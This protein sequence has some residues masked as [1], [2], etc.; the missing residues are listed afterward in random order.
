MFIQEGDSVRQHECF[1]FKIIQST[2]YRQ[3]SSDRIYLK[4]QSEFVIQLE[5][6]L[7]CRG[8]SYKHNNPGIQATHHPTKVQE[9]T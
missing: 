5:Q 4:P 9:C 7:S 8:T 1:S 6:F 3:T 2:R